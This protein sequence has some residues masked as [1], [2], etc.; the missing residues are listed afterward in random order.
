LKHGDALLFNAH[1][2]IGNH[3]VP[4][5]A[6]LSQRFAVRRFAGAQRKRFAYS[7]VIHT[8]EFTMFTLSSTATKISVLAFS[9]FAAV[10]SMDTV[11]VGFQ[12][13]QPT[14]TVVTLPS[15]TIVGRRADDEQPSIQTASK[16]VAKTSL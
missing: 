7:R 10:G 16:D 2:T 12:L 14:V 6:T 11:T 13:Q 15:V 5:F 9:A 3:S 8:K 4:L 1:T